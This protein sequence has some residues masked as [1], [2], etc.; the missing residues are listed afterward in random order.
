MPK[1]VNYILHIRS[2]YHMSF[3]R[4]KASNRNDLFL[5]FLGY[6][7]SQIYCKCSLAINQHQP[8]KGVIFLGG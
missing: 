4:N 6:W 7:R 2:V 5:H 1:L 3:I 8:T